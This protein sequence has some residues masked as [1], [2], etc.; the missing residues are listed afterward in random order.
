MKY[1]SEDEAET[2]FDD[3]IDSIDSP[4]TILGMQYCAST[5]LKEV[6][7]TA[8]NCCMADWLDSEDLTTDENEADQEDD[9]ENE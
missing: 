7:P 5:V 1:I 4:V 6:D 9:G 3:Y 2:L 8:Y